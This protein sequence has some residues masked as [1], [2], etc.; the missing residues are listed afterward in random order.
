MKSWQFSSEVSASTRDSHKGGIWCVK[1]NSQ[2]AATVSQLT[3]ASI[4]FVNRKEAIILTQDGSYKLVLSEV[5]YLV[6]SD[7]LI[8]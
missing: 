1:G 2:F 8:G 7:S 6:S 5:E 4:E 3:D